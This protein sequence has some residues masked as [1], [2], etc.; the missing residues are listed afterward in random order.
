[1]LPAVLCTDVQNQFKF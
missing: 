1:M